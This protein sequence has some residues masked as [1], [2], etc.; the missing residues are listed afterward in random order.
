MNLPLVLLPGMMCDARVFSDQILALSQ[1]HVV[2]LAPISQDTRIETIASTLLARLPQRFALAGLSMG[3]IVAMEMLRQAPDRIDRACLMGASPLPETPD[4][5]A[6]REPMIVGARAGRLKDALRTALPPE[7]LAPGPGRAEVLAQLDVMG[8]DLGV[9]VFVRQCRALQRRRDQQ[10]TLAKCKVPT[11]V[12]CGEHDT[13]VP[14]KRHEVLAGLMPNAELKVIEGA[15]HIPSLEQP[16]QLNAVL[17]GWL[18]G[19][20]VL[21]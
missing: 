11:L 21:R 4:M 17:R 6:E 5:A 19:P 12:L 13:L 2:I 1:D 18:D 20:L 8:H 16:A 10:A 3:G 15:G 14:P 7:A 9:D